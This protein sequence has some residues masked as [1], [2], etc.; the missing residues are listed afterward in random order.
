MYLFLRPSTLQPTH[1]PQRSHRPCHRAHQRGVHLRGAHAQDLQG[2]LADD[3]HL[4]GRIHLFL[5]G[6]KPVLRKQLDSIS[7]QLWKDVLRTK[8]NSSQKKS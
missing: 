2:H 4:A 1:F 5:K 8:K 7:H 6:R 3:A